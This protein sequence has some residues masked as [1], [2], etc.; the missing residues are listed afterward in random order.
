MGDLRLTP[1]WRKLMS[2]ASRYDA[3]YEETWARLCNLVNVGG[4]NISTSGLKILGQDSIPAGRIQPGS[5]WI[6]DCRG[7]ITTSGAAPTGFSFTEYWQGTGGTLIGELDMGASGLWT[8]ASNAA[9]QAFSIIDWISDNETA[10]DNYVFWRTAAG[11]DNSKPYT[12]LTH[13]TSGLTGGSAGSAGGN[14]T[15]AFQWTGSGSFDFN[16]IDCRVAQVA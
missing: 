10:V 14:L 3:N 6:A 2:I 11:T 13:T 12:S 4:N 1:A 5:R 15:Y 7:S 9:I 8:G 16:M